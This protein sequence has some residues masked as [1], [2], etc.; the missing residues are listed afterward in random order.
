MLFRSV[1]P[2]LGRHVCAQPSTAALQHAARRQSG[3][4]ELS[5]VERSA[6]QCR[7]RS[8]S[9]GS[10]V[11]PSRPT[12]TMGVRSPLSA[13]GPRGAAVLVL[14]LLLLGRVALCSAVEE[15]KGNGR[16]GWRGSATALLGVPLG[17]AGRVGGKVPA[18]SHRRKKERKK[19]KKKRRE[20][21]KNKPTAAIA[22]L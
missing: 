17:T 19:K 5:G 4:S 18:S 9:S 14:L 16:C 11:C 7:V 13:S 3:S 6:E 1:R 10:S 2:Q 20:R 22:Q 12:H 21:W 8:S 15:K